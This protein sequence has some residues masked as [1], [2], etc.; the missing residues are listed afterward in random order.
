[1]KNQ[2]AVPLEDYAEDSTDEELDAE[3]MI[4]AEAIELD[5]EMAMCVMQQTDGVPGKAT[6]AQLPAIPEHG[7]VGPYDMQTIWRRV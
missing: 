3:G 1:M 5:Q 4:A 7:E 2:T 6:V